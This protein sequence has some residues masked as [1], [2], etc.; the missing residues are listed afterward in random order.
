MPNL[1]KEISRHNSKILKPKS[2]TSEA[3]CNCLQT[4]ECPM[5]G[6]CLTNR[7][8]YKATVTGPNIPTETYTGVTKNT[9]K[10]RYYGHSSSFRNREQEFSTTLSS[11]IGSLKDDDK[12][13][14]IRWQVIDRGREFN[15][16]TRKCLLCMKEKYH[17]IH[18]SY[19]SSLNLRSELFS[20]CRHRT[21]NLLSNL[22]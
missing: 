3:G 5:P 6:K 15:P 16:T 7:L 10:Q 20:T 9:F 17:I 2:T 22:Q 11:H 12:E 19:G 1:K 13:Y 4:S 14:D 21:K 18:N 8:V